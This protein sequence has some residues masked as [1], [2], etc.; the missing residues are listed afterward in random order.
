MIKS[1]PGMTNN[2]LPGSVN[3]G[4]TVTGALIILPWQVAEPGYYLGGLMK[5][6][7]SK[8]YDA[9]LGCYIGSQSPA[10]TP[11]QR[12]NESQ[13]AD[14][15]MIFSGRIAL[16]CLLAFFFIIGMIALRGCK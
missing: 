12:E 7:T 2:T 16:V 6:R 11:H 9:E 4:R 14:Q 13:Q 3:N 5:D 15:R 1:L 8:D 10:L